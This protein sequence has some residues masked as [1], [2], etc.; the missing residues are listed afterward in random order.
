MRVSNVIRTPGLQRVYHYLVCVVRKKES[1]I[2]VVSVRVNNAMRMPL[3]SAFDDE[4]YVCVCV[5]R[6]LNYYGVS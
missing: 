4:V 3:A 2:L 5:V 6:R 1:E